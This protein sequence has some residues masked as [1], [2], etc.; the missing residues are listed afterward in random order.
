[1]NKE[2]QILFPF[3]PLKGRKITAVFDEPM[4]SS[5]GGLALLREALIE[6]GI[7]RSLAKALPD[8]RHPSYVDHSLEEMLSQ[9]VAQICC[10]Y[11]DAD[12]C[13]HL[14]DDPLFKM[15]AGRLPEADRRP[16]SR[17]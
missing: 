17:R 2:N 5:D 16:P 9:R 1:M 4:V 8:P 11:E 13:D 6:T 12:D 14:R 3:T 15:A 10:G 7:I